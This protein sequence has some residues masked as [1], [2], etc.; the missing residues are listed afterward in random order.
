MTLRARAHVN[1]GKWIASCPYEHCANAERLRPRQPEFFCTNCEQAPVPVEWPADADDIWTVLS[2]RPV[3]QTRNW[4]PFGHVDALSW[5]VP[6]GQ[7]VADLI[8]E[9]VAHGLL[10]DRGGQ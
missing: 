3:P 4:Y 10:A 9:N 8:E 6:H 2:L 5:G 7:S 1:H